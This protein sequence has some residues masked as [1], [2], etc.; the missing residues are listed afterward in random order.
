MAT[1]SVSVVTIDIAKASSGI[2]EPIFVAV[3]TEL[4]GPT[5][6]SDW[7]HYVSTEIEAA[8]TAATFTNPAD[9]STGNALT[10]LDKSRLRA[11]VSK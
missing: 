7:A 6:V 10:V 3:A 8:L 1:G 11:F 4:G 9:G 5:T 2:S